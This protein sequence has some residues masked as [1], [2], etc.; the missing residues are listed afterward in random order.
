[1]KLTAERLD[2]LVLNV[3]DVEVSAAWYGRVLGMEREDFDPGRGKPRRTALKF[4]RQKINLR[5][6]DAGID[7]W[8]TAAHPA[9][10]VADLCFITAEGPVR[11]VAHLNSCGVAVEEGP[12]RRQGALGPIHSVYCRDPDG[13]LIEIASYPAPAPSIGP[14]AAATPGG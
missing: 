5:P 6:V 12:V 11:V 3:R 9:A 4:G 7:D 2:H 1:V 8:F 13:S 14:E 10:G